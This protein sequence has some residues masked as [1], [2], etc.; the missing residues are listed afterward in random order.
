M[1]RVTRIVHV[2]D[3]A[4]TLDHIQALSDRALA[5]PDWAWRA[6]M[7]ALDMTRGVEYRLL[8]DGLDAAL[9]T[10]C[11]IP[12]YVVSEYTNLNT[13]IPDFSDAASLGCL[14][15]IVRCKGGGSGIITR[16]L[17][18]YGH[19]EAMHTHGP[20]KGKRVS[21]HGWGVYGL[22]C[23]GVLPVGDSEAESLVVALEIIGGV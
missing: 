20:R 22:N 17:V 4:T 12:D 5:C 11:T 1:L 13:C 14:L 9:A 18:D 23:T 15:D 7:R 2:E 10:E 16:R 3:Q 21:R 8:R 19:D 6:G